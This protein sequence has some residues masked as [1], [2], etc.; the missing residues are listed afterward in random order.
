MPQYHSLGWR[1]LTPVNINWDLGKKK[2]NKTYFVTLKIS[3][4]TEIE[5]QHTNNCNNECHT[6]ALNRKSQGSMEGMTTCL[7]R[8]WQVVSPQNWEGWMDAV[9]WGENRNVLVERKACSRHEG[10][11]QECAGVVQFCSRVLGRGPSV[12]IAE[13]LR[14]KLVDRQVHNMEDLLAHPEALGIYP[15][16]EK[17]P[18][19][20]SY[21]LILV[22]P[23]SQCEVGTAA[24]Q[25]KTCT[26]S[27]NSYWN[28]MSKE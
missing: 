8:I 16:F 14:M 15:E 6:K 3:L 18:W 26:T 11:K 10:R 17:A 4:S 22:Y 28:W 27:M 21:A 13:W 20:R 9:A 2:M 7:W 23:G 1:I 24:D 19:K 12:G 25:W 5:R